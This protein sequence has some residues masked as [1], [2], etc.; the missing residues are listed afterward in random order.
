MLI[1]T[2]ANGTL[3][4]L[5]VEHLLA[6]VPA[7]QIAVSVRE[8]DRFAHRGVRARKGDYDDPASLR[9]AFEG[10][11][12]ILIISCSPTAEV[13][14]RR[15]KA[16]IDAAVA[17]GARRIVYTSHM[18]ASPG[19]QFT[20]MHAHAHTEE[21]LAACGVPFVALRNGLY[22]ATAMRALGPALD[23]GT[24]VAP[25]DGPVSWTTHADLAEATAIV[26][27]SDPFRGISP[28]LTGPIAQDLADVARV[29]TEVTGR[30]IDRVVVPDAAYRAQMAQRMPPELADV[31]IG[32]YPASR[33][34]EFART[35]PALGKLL[36]REPQTV[37][38]LIRG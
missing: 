4:K 36:G 34:G 6:R 29:A 5:V 19:S 23:S 21:L 16:A 32:I 8:P 25:A 17:V 11:S 31:L 18:G 7:D 13:A 27:T 24:L 35:D 14:S 2:G 28:P 30:K 37:R 22:A 10:A 38:D 15:H 9:H 26:L 3:G 1:V 33:A 20:P 12:D